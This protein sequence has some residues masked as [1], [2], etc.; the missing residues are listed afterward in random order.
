MVGDR[1]YQRQTPLTREGLKNARVQKALELLGWEPE[2]AWQYIQSGAT[3]G[4]SMKEAV[5]K[6]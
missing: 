3:I 1:C 2:D 6:A 4:L 5:Y